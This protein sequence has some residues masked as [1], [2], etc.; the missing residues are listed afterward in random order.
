[1]TRLVRAWSAMEP[2]SASPRSPRLRCSSRCS[3]RGMGCRASTARAA[4]S[5]PTTSTRS[6][7]SFVEAAIFL[8]AAG[9]LAMLFARAERREFQLPGGDGMIVTIAG[10]WATLLIFYRVF[11]RP[12]GQRVL[13]SASIGASSSL[14][15]AAGALTYAGWRMR[16]HERPAP[17]L[18]RP[19]EQRRA[20]RAT[21]ALR[22]PSRRAARR[23]RAR[24]RPRPSPRASAAPTL[25]R[26][27][28][29]CQGRRARVGPARA[30]V[31]R[32]S[33]RARAVTASGARLSLR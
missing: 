3:S 8:V 18:R 19:R 9:V 24:P 28:S 30:A 5:T 6:A 15:V 10:G 33:T 11:D 26:L 27:A 20:S 21:R 14:F 29:A 7:L 1:M 31:L 2:S 16:A 13:P 4:P 22:S 12:L 17:P 23:E 32:G 25:R